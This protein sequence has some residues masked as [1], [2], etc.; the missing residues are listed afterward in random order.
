VIDTASQPKAYV[1]LRAGFGFCQHVRGPT[2]PAVEIVDCSDKGSASLR[3]ELDKSSGRVAS[4]LIA[5]AS[6]QHHQKIKAFSTSTRACICSLPVEMTQRIARRRDKIYVRYP[7]RARYRRFGRSA[8]SLVAR[9]TWL[10]LLIL[11]FR[12]GPGALLA[13]LAEPQQHVTFRTP[14]SPG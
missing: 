9:P 11:A 2:S 10:D 12:F 5:S 1:D 3:F 8:P 13:S 4:R 7:H 6:R 14:P